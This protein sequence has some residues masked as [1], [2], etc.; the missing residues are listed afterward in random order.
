[1]AAR[2]EDEENEGQATK[3]TGAWRP[4]AHRTLSQSN[5]VR[6]HRTLFAW[7]LT[8]PLGPD[9]DP[10]PED[11]T[12]PH[13]A[14]ATWSSPFQNHRFGSVMTLKFPESPFNGETSACHDALAG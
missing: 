10:Q 5:N 11:V 13:L 7:P 1:M 4:A 3:I 14:M 8:G 12:L 2:N 6:T 9:H